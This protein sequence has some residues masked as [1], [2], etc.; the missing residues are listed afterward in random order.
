MEVTDIISIYSWYECQCLFPAV[1]L[2]EAGK[3]FQINNFAVSNK[4]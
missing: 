2:F 1:F 4:L 3:A